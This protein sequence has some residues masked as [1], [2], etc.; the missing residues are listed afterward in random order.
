MIHLIRRRFGATE[1]KAGPWM[2][3]FGVAVDLF[4]DGAMIGTGSTITLSPGILL[5]LGQIPADFPAGTAF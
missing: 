1:G 5:G 2:I 4:S 3:Y